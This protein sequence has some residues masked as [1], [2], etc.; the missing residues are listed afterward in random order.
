MNI[1]SNYSTIVYLS[2][3]LRDF[4]TFNT[5]INRKYLL[6]ESGVWYKNKICSDYSVCQKDDDLELWFYKE[7][8]LTN[9]Y[10]FPVSSTSEFPF[11][12]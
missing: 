7:I 2:V 9:I 3:K 5:M 12:R 6:D 1:A 11:L 10:K 4:K 8:Q